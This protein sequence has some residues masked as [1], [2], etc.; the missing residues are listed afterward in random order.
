MKGAKEGD[1][2][3]HALKLANFLLLLQLPGLRSTQTIVRKALGAL[4][5][6]LAIILFAAPDARTARPF[7]AVVCW[8][9]SIPRFSRSDRG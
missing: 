4:F 9:G 5:S 2:S 1:S 6:C 3:E 8:D 7:W